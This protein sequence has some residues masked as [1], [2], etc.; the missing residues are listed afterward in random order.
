[1]NHQD[2]LAALDRLRRV[3]SG[4]LIHVVY[5]GENGPQDRVSD[6]LTIY[7]FEHNDTPA[8]VEWLASIG[9]KQ[10]NSA[11]IV[12]VKLSEAITAWDLQPGVM[13]TIYGLDVL[14]NPTRGEVRTLLR[15]F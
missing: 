11:G 8:T 5:P 10:V 3:A 4:E 15:V 6:K 2:Y 12:F 1:M 7:D 13:L 14:T 9:D